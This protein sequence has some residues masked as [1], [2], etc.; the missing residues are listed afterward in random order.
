MLAVG[1]VSQAATNGVFF[2]GITLD[3]FFDLEYTDQFY[4]TKSSLSPYV[5]FDQVYS[6]GKY[7]MCTQ[8]EY[9]AYD[10]RS[11]EGT[12]T[13]VGSTLQQGSVCIISSTKNDWNKMVIRGSFSLDAD[14][15][16]VKCAY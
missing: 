10:W 5:K 2:E 15:E 12:T 13:K 16:C 14:I 7:S 4:C 1:L 6:A 3:S 11:L 8:Y 9:A